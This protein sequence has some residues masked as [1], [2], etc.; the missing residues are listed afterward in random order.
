M[1]GVETTMIYTHVPWDRR[2][3]PGAEPLNLYAPG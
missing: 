3:L 2:P 1:P